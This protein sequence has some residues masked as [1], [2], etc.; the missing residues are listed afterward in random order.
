MLIVKC[1]HKVS[2]YT[3]VANKGPEVLSWK[4]EAGAICTTNNNL[5]DTT[6]IDA[7]ILLGRDI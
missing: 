5:A 3:I 2:P 7:Y 1:Q 4:T 6:L